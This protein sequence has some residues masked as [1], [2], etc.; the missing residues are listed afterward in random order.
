MLDEAGKTKEAEAALERL[1]FVNPLDQDLHEKLGALYLK[2]GN[3]DARGARIRD[4]RS[5]QAARR[6]GQPL[7]SC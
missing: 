7:Q 2:T 4:A 5:A 3:S 6:G 1:N